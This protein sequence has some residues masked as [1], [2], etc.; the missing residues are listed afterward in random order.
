MMEDSPFSSQD[1]M[2]LH[3]HHPHMNM[4]HHLQ[5]P[6]QL[7]MQLYKQL[8]TLVITSSYD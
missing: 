1:A 2:W 6:I 8:Q 5:L 4:W 3:H 7:Q